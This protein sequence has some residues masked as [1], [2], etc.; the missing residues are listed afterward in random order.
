MNRIF[1]EFHLVCGGLAK[2][3]DAL[4]DV[5]TLAPLG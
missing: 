4:P 3:N 1:G 5:L 2:C